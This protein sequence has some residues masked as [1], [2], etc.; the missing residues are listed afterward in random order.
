MRRG[1][2]AWVQSCVGCIPQRTFICNGAGLVFSWTVT[3]PFAIISVDIWSPGDVVSADG[4]R[5]LFNVMCDMSQFVVCQG[6]KSKEASYGAR[7]LMEGVLLR[8][9]LCAMVVCDQGNKN[10]GVFKKA[11]TALNICFHAV[12]KHNHKAV[13]V[14]RFH[15]FLNH[16]QRVYCT[17]RGSP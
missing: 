6:C 15:G 9:G 1:I 2:I 13:G 17:K 14:K 4:Y 12:S 7:L 11:C 16:A 8:F 5:Y 10:H 3:T